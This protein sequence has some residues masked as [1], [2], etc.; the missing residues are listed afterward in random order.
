[1]VPLEIPDRHRSEATRKALLTAGEDLFA[2][3]GFSGASVDLI[4]RKAGVNKA[5]I[6]YHFGGKA[7]LYEA[8]LAA[9]LGP[10]TERLRDL[11]VSRMPADARLREY[12]E[13]FGAM[14]AE[15]PNLS[16]MVLHEVLS[17]G[18]HI[19]DRLMPRLVG[20]MDLVREIVAAGV[21]DGSFRPIDPTMTHLTI[22]G[23]IILFFATDRLRRRLATE[24]RAPAVAPPSREYVRHVQEFVRRGLAADRPRPAEPASTEEH[25]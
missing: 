21:E 1:L 13:V 25:S 16:V 9:A 2:Q 4:A 12:L 22:M 11:R 10:V 20:L 14:H 5:M 3:Y 7:G 19:G 6:S 23:S 15:H 17:G 18:R 8:I 24:G